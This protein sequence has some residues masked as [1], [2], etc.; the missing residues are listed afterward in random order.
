[1]GHAIPID[2]G[3][4]PDPPDHLFAESLEV[5][6]GLVTVELDPIEGQK[7]AGPHDLVQRRV[8]KDTDSLHP[9]DVANPARGGGIEGAGCSQPENETEQVGAGGDCRLGV[10]GAGNAAYLDQHA[11][12]QLLRK[13]EESDQ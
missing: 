4:D 3:T 8:E 10:L 9:P 7:I 5:G 13:I 12:L 6:I 11:N 2:L 1:M